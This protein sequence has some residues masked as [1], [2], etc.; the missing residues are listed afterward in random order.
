M[1]TTQ[2]KQKK[3]RCLEDL[4]KGMSNKKNYKLILGEPCTDP[5]GLS[6][7]IFPAALTLLKKERG[8]LTFSDMEEH[9]HTAF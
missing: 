7:P 6:P 3:K 2:D 8:Q 9:N 5:N 1:E 4:C